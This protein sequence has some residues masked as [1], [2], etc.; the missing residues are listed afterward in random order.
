METMRTRADASAV[1]REAK[2]T[3]A[4]HIIQAIHRAVDLFGIKGNVYPASNKN[5][6]KERRYRRV[7][8]TRY[9]IEMPEDILL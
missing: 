9:Y 2:I 5:S 7:R 4:I 1:I 3:V 8:S 6:P